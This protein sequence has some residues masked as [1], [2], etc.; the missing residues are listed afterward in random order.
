MI[1]NNDTMCN[2]RIKGRHV[3]EQKHWKQSAN[4]HPT[5]LYSWMITPGV[6]QK[7]WHFILS[8][9]NQLHSQYLMYSAC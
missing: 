4:V 3:S 5:Q 2:L 1:C 7:T 6:S 8:I 9:T